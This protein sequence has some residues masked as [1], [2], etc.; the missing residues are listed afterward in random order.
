MVRAHLSLE[1][2]CN[3]VCNIVCIISFTP[4][5]E[6]TCS[7]TTGFLIHISIIPVCLFTGLTAVIKLIFNQISKDLLHP[8]KVKA[9]QLVSWLQ[10]V[11]AARI[12]AKLSCS[13]HRI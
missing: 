4:R 5:T 12:K 7:C 1:C 13:R 2:K 10:L 3:L 8:F 9:E 11:K 6:Q